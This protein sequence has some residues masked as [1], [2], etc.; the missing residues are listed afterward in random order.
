[1]GWVHGFTLFFVV[2]EKVGEVFVDVGFQGVSRY[3]SHAIDKFQPFFFTDDQHVASMQQHPACFVRFD[4][5]E[6]EERR[7]MRLLEAFGRIS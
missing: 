6:I 3:Q 1:M 4:T 7:D 5:R 2:H